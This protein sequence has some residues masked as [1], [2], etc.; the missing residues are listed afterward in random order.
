MSNLADTK[1]AN[2]QVAAYLPGAGVGLSPEPT[3]WV[4]PGV[5]RTSCQV[6][7]FMS[8]LIRM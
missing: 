1:T 7:S 6:F 5:W 3:I 2:G 8:M 4:T